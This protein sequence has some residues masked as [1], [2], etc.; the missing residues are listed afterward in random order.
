MDHDRQASKQNGSVRD[1][2]VRGVP[3][4][5]DALL[6]NPPWISK[7]ENI[8]HGIKGAMPPLGLLSIAAYAEQQGWSVKILDV[9]VERWDIAQFRAALELVVPRTVGISVMTATTIAGNRIARIVKEVHPDCTVVVGG[10]HSE[11]QPTECL[12]NRAIDVVVRGDGERT[13][14][15]LLS[16]GPWREIRGI[17]FREGDRAVHTPPADVIE[18]LDELP[19]PAYHLVPM[20]KY[21]PAMG[22]YRRLPAINM[23]M[24]RGCPGKCTFC[25]SA[26]TKLR[27]RS[28]DLV[29][30]EIAY[31]RRTYGIREIQFY[32]DTFTVLKKN[33]LRFCR[34]MKE[35]NLG[36]SWTAFVR[37]DCFSKEMAV[38]L[39]EGGCHQ[40]MFGVESGDDEILRNIRKPIDREQTRA[41]IRLAQKVGLE[42][43]ATFMLGNPGETVESM[44]RTTSYAL[45][46][47]PDLAVFNI[48]TPY[49]GTQMFEWA[50]QNGYLNTEDWSDYEL[51][52]AIMT[53]PTVSPEKISEQYNRAHRVFYNRPIMFWRRLMRIRNLSHFVDDIHAFFYI[54]LRRKVGTRG[55]SR[56]EWIDAIKE[57]FWDVPLDDPVLGDRLIRTSEVHTLSIEAETAAEPA[58]SVSLPV[59]AST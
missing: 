23:L 39:K 7:D 38:G 37:T 26:N 30:E 53:L 31:L 40:V 47:D 2:L 57:D 54:I 43:R 33:A 45:E 9:H 22:A 17:S 52:G 25:N 55:S 14:E 11:A 13:F 34:L 42:V 44:Q 24:T 59:L 58:P 28:A 1:G 16:G 4:V 21:Y 29:V 51:S 56:R 49:P 19:M 12:R 5:V 3:E 27:A 48:T 46:L 20:K 36:V 8:W 32:D 10:V 15:S 35:R 41:A 6:I 18:N 50:K